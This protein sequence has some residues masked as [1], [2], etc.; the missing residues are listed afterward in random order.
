MKFEELNVS[1]EIKLSL[2]EM[3]FSETTEVQEKSI[4]LA[5]EGNDLIVRSQTGT[6]KTA[7]FGIVLVEKVLKEGKKSIVLAPTREL[8]I[9][10]FN[11]LR[12]IAGN[13]NIKIT[14]VYGGESIDRQLTFLRKKPDIVI[15]TPGRLIDHNNRGNIDLGSYEIVV[16]DEA[17]RMLDMGFIDDIS[18]ILDSINEIEQIMLFSATINEEIINIIGP[19]SSVPVII[20]VGKEEKPVQVEEEKI[21]IKG[22]NKFKILNSILKENPGRTM[23]FLSTRK[24]VEDLG[25]RLKQRRYRVGYL[26]GGLKQ[27][28]RENIMK[29]FRNGKF[30]IL[31]A[32]DV[33]A[34]GLHID[35]VELVINYHEAGD[36]KTH[37]HRVGRT[38][39]MGKK[40]KVVTFVDG[41]RI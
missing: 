34:R 31:V 29:D 40:G 17:D 2:K 32:T 3:G 23:I 9:Q 7:A 38:G 36:E 14:V 28:R 39:R 15:A 12:K 20:E 10:I 30:N 19:Y 18:L 37:I 6:G 8:A 13:S 26:H 5:L 21:V 4:P 1:P 33:A 35:D 25:E 22:P 41:R 24:S 16:L 27:R 11:D